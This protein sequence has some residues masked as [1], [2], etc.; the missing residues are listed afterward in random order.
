MGKIAH[1]HLGFPARLKVAAAIGIANHRS[2]VGDIYPP[3]IRSGRIEPEANTSLLLGLAAP[4]AARR[5]RIRPGSD[6]AFGATRTMRG[7]RKLEANSSTSK[8]SG[9]F[10]VA[11]DRG[12]TTHGGSTES[13]VSV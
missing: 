1:D 2:R 4:S 12:P 9:T 8:P 7:S 5:T 13:A 6:S 10:G 3:R 11:E